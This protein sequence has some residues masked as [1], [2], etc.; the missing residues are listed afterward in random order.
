MD[1]KD[2]KSSADPSC[3][4]GKPE[5]A[6]SKVGPAL[7][8]ESGIPV[9]LEALFNACRQLYPDQPNPLQVTALVKYWSVLTAVTIFYEQNVTILSSDAK[10]IF[11]I[12]YLNDYIQLL[13]LDSKEKPKSTFL[14]TYQ[15]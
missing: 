6:H 11:I 9:G 13:V 1:W 14:M 12:T 2:G 5:A 7:S 15:N 10:C 3:T 8:T 4:S